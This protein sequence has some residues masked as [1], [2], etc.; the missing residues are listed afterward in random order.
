MAFKVHTRL[1]AL[2]RRQHVFIS[3][4]VVPRPAAAAS[5]L[6]FGYVTA[7]RSGRSSS[8]ANLRDVTDR[9]DCPDHHSDF[10]IATRLLM[11]SCAPRQTFQQSPVAWWRFLSTMARASRD[12]PDAEP[13]RHLAEIA[14]GCWSQTRTRPYAG[15]PVWCLHR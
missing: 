4:P 12:L 5:C 3:R 13:V 6:H 2:H 15:C 9:T 11:P 10:A 7:A 1:E 8:R 14:P